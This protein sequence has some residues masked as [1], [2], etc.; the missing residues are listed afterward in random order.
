MPAKEAPTPNCLRS[1]TFG[2]VLS[3]RRLRTPTPIQSANVSRYDDPPKTAPVTDHK[4]VANGPLAFVTMAVRESGHHSSA[5]L[6][7]RT[8]GNGRID[9]RRSPR[10]C[11]AGNRRHRDQ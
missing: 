6:L 8:Q 10:R 3:H 7:L 11:P 5:T 9:P 4:G 1:R 2:N